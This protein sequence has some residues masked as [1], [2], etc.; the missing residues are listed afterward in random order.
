MAAVLPLELL[1]P[2]LKLTDEKPVLRAV[3]SR[4]LTGRVV[5]TQDGRQE[6]EVRCVHRCWQQLI[7]VEIETRQ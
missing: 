4:E 5:S 3:C 7:R 6:P 1:P 2:L